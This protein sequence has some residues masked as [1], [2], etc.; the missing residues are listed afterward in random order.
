MSSVPSQSGTST[1]ESISRDKF[2][3]GK[4][5]SVGKHQVEIVNYIAEGGFAQ[6]YSV[7]FVEY[8]N[9]FGKDTNIATSLK[10]GD[11]A[12][13]KRVIVHDEN[14]LN[15]LRNEVE[16]MKKL[17]GSPNIIQYYDSN[18]SR[19]SNSSTG[20]E[21]L[22]LMELCPN[23][24]LLDYMNQRLATKLSEKEV[25]K[26][27]YDITLA[28]SQM[29]YLSEPLLHRDIKIENVLVDS[30]NNF[31]LCDF[32]SASKIF[33]IV[34]S[35]QDIA[36]LT[37]NIYVHTT[38]QYRSP[39]MIDLYRYL[40]INEKSDIW[41][42][43]VFLYKLLFFTTPFEMTGQ[44]AMLHSKYE[45]PPNNFSSKLNNLIII[46]L[47][48]NP[49][50]RPNIYQIMY[51]ICSIIGVPVPIKDNYEMGPYNFENYTH[52]QNKLQN[53]QYQIFQLEK[54]KVENSGK[55]TDVENNMI[56]DMFI[57]SFDIASKVPVTLRLTSPSVNSINQV[58]SNDISNS[59]STDQLGSTT[60]EPNGHLL[61]H[62]QERLSSNISNIANSNLMV[63]SS[64]ERT[65]KSESLKRD[66]KN[67]NQ[68]TY[69]PGTGELN[70]YIEKEINLPI[71]NGANEMSQLI[72]PARDK[73]QVSV[74]SVISD[75]KRSPDSFNLSN[76]PPLLNSTHETASK[77]ENTIGI[78]KQYKSNNPFPEMDFDPSQQQQQ[79]QQQYIQGQ[80]PIDNTNYMKSSTDIGSRSILQQQQNQVLLNQA[81][82]NE[83]SLRVPVFQQVAMTQNKKMDYVPNNQVQF[84]QNYSQV[85][86]TP[87]INQARNQQQ[88]FSNLFAQ[89]NSMNM[90]PA[91]PPIQ[92]GQ[93]PQNQPLE[94]IV[95]ENST[96]DLPPKVP[97][98]PKKKDKS[99]IDM[100][101]PR[102]P[103]HR[104][105]Q[106]NFNTNNGQKHTYKHHP[107]QSHS[108]NES[109]DIR[110]NVSMNNKSR[111][112]LERPTTESID[113]DLDK[114]KRKSLDLKVQKRNFTSDLKDQ[115]IKENEILQNNNNN[116]TSLDR[117]RLGGKNDS[118]SSAS[119]STENSNEMKKSIARARQ[120]L[121]LDRARREALLTNDNTKRH[122]FFSMFRSDKKL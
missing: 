44:F 110:R 24:S 116:R 68:E 88:P 81:A 47:A 64:E 41:A 35:Y 11:V 23:G 18:A 75:S 118:N 52:F 42:L 43:G 60:P 73:R 105:R 85:N 28:L 49:N 32:G 90:A 57:S 120:S 25:L 82:V 83:T 70:S 22:L 21:I 31:K 30:D 58:S 15:E 33:Q 94:A 121:D 67:T 34:T 48:E 97:P 55:L 10:I 80:Q 107:K 76:K 3:P 19:L 2:N 79:Q 119:V 100:S 63:N 115:S 5:V 14:G 51:Q 93:P 108:G 103:S 7:K 27:M 117:I 61:M 39:E 54:R 112:L 86:P 113:I 92:N 50:L 99:L 109:S 104:Y 8:L 53:I 89:Q 102:E 20:F 45:M 17:K 91:K 114:L 56:N 74:D 77:S 16:I 40:P 36:M 29:H 106:E 38:P 72:A 69:F 1:K 66:E 122:S 4:L 65:G 98:H 6:I 96:E 78:L 13:L 62:S 101:T 71:V 87:T 111:S 37:Q 95:L 84:Q 59:N 26:I 9:E 46:M 12:C